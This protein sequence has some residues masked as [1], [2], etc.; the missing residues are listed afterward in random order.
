MYQYDNTNLIDE[1]VFELKPSLYRIVV[2]N[3]ISI[4]IPLILL[5]VVLFNEYNY[6]YDFLP[7]FVVILIFAFLTIIGVIFTFGSY[8]AGK[9][10]K[11]F[12]TKEH[13]IIDFHSFTG[14]RINSIK[15]KIELK[16]LEKVSYHSNFLDLI[17]ASKCGTLILD[18][19][20]SEFLKIPYIKN[21]QDAARKASRVIEEANKNGQEE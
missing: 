16:E 14:I 6:L 4:L 19:K 20:D 21:P 15:A 11:Y 9:R 13:F 3:S 18:A 5:P 1:V 10:T 2:T 8:V 17:S 7:D 12:F